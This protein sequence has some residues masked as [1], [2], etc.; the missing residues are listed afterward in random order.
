MTGRRGRQTAS[1]VVGLVALVALGTPGAHGTNA[2][3]APRRPSNATKHAD[4]DHA[5][6]AHAAEDH[7]IHDAATEAR[8][9]RTT[10]ELT[11]DSAAAAAAATAGTPDVVGRWSP[12]VDWPVVG[13]SAALLPDGDVLAFDSV[14]DH[15]GEAYPVQTFTRATVFDPTTGSQT[16]VENDSGYNVFCSGLAHLVDGTIYVAG[17]NKDN[18]LAG[19]VQT[20]TFDPATSLWSTGADMAQPRWYPTVTALRSGEM[21]ITSGGPPVPEIRKVDGTLRS[22]PGAELTQPLYP[23]MVVAPDGRAYA[24]GPDSTIR[25]LD[26]SGDGAWTTVGTRD[27]L[28][29]TYGGHALFDVGKVLVAGGGPSTPTAD[30]IDLNGP[31]P[32]VSSSSSMAYGRR[33]NN[34]T[35]LADGSVLATGGNSSGSTYVDLAAAVYAAERWDPATGQWTTMASAQVTR[36]YHSTALLLPDGRVLTAGGGVCSACDDVGYL[37]KNAE[38]FSPP[39]LFAKD[40]SGD[41]APRPTVTSAP[42]AITYGSG[43]DV[44][45]PDA[46]SITKAA[47]VRLGAV[48]HSNDMDQRYVPL[49]LTAGDGALHLT[50]PASSSIAPPGYYMLFVVDSNGV[51]SVAKMVHVDAVPDTPPSVRFATPVDGATY[52]VGS[53]VT[54]SID[55]DDESDIDRV[56]L[57]AD[58]LLIATDRTYPYSFS[59]T[60][61]M[62]GVFT[63]TARAVDDTGQSSTA[64]AIVTLR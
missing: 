3:A 15:G 11:A 14:G 63:L 29:R 9:E 17:G 4:G 58:G 13:V 27:A 12:V 20:H 10:R 22:L 41:L 8:L 34:L 23:W 44:T 19:I 42:A 5:A 45:T 37:A 62:P 28:N 43:F 38:I 52:F 35:V 47:L 31:A 61:P 18:T 32:V 33:Q 16:N 53:H 50:A 64:S 51:P 60:V 59:G 54:I 1:L 46:A 40:G 25:R 24:V 30:V 57:L 26:T 2:P 7:V 39:Y 49:P 48:T 56:E 36:Q 6:D 21:L 55:A